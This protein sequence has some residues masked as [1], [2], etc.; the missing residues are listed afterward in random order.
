MNNWLEELFGVKKPIIAMCHL[1]PLP[2]DP[3]YD[4]QGGMAKGSWTAP[5]E[6]F[7]LCRTAASMPSCFPMNFRCPI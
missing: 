2:G 5:E 4:K 7:T 6:T 1:Q 3:Y